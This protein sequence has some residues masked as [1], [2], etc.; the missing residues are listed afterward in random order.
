MAVGGV[1]RVVVYSRR[2]IS[3]GEELTYD[4]KFP[5]EMDNKIPCLCGSSKCRGFLN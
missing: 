3:Q 5:T 4:Y 2:A 1:R